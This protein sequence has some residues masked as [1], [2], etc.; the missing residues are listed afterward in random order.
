MHV[1]NGEQRLREE[2]ARLV[3]WARF[4]GRESPVENHKPRLVHRGDGRWE[5]CCPGC[6]RIQD[7]LF[8]IGIGIPIVSRIEAEAIVRNHTETAV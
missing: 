6:E 2:L 3:G 4:G 7:Q 5:V 1:G 8:P